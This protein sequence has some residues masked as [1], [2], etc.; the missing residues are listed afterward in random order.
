MKLEIRD[1]AGD[2]GAGY[3]FRFGPWLNTKVNQCVTRSESFEQKHGRNALLEILL[4][5]N[6][7]VK[8][9]MFRQLQTIRKKQPVVIHMVIVPYI[10]SSWSEPSAYA[11]PV[12]QWLDG[13]AT[14]LRGLKFDSSHFEERIPALLKQFCSDPSVI[15]HNLVE[16][17]KPL[18][19]AFPKWRVPKDIKKHV[20]EADGTWEDERYDPILLMVSE[21]GSYDGRSIP[22]MWQIEFD[23]FDDRLEVALER[24]QDSGL[25]PDGDVWSSLIQKRFRKRFPKFARELHCDS[26][27]GTCVLWVE[28][29]PAC[30]ALMELTWAMLFKK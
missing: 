30:K 11:Q 7:R 29:E 8:R 14:V 3:P 19:K 22:L 10:G 9:P 25:D 5:T 6:L 2:Y 26:E 15:L 21:G 18:P 27:S 17:P 13:V 28:S 23:P 12:Q 1:S 24:L 4:F 20:K 16:T